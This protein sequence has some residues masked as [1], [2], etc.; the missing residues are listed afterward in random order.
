VR[1]SG[2]GESGLAPRA[3]WAAVAAI[4]QVASTDM[5]SFRGRCF[6]LL[7][8]ADRYQRDRHLRPAGLPVVPRGGD[9]LRGLWEYFCANEPLLAA[10]GHGMSRSG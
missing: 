9:Y 4:A 2:H 5:G 10:L 1:T 8:S 3:W 7:H 6:R